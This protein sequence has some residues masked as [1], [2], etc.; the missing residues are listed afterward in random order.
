MR[1]WLPESRAEF[2]WGDVFVCQS[3][4]SW[5]VNRLPKLDLWYVTHGEGWLEG[6]GPDRSTIRAGDC[7][8]LRPDGTFR[9]GCVPHHHPQPSLRLIAVHFNLL[10]TDGRRYALPEEELPPFLRRMGAPGLFAELLERAIDCYRDGC[11][12]WASTWLQAT[13]MEV[14]RQDAQT[15]PPGLLG[16]RARKIEQICSRIRAEPGRV[17]RVE[18][19]AAELHVSAEHFCRIFRS[20]QG[21]SPRAFMTKTRIESAK[22]LL[23]T[24]NYSIA[25]IA[26]L[27]GYVDL[28]HFSRQFKH[29]VGISPSK[30]RRSDRHERDSRPT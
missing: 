12:D 20:L 1:K 15:W 10:D 11:H 16:D 9:A 13:L 7:I 30:F 28:F 24:S 2:V 23:M 8:L 27:L 22:T 19:L 18:E 17:W 5:R 4:W 29:K 14:I 3:D 21:T 6:V 25:R 26:D